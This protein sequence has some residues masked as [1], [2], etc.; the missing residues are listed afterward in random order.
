MKYYSW[1]FL[2]WKGVNCAQRPWALARVVHQITRNLEKKSLPK[3]CNLA[4]V[5]ESALRVII[6]WCGA[7][8]IW[9]QRLVTDLRK[10]LNIPHTNGM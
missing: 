10:F 1:S 4:G 7:F 9:R 8:S 2:E 3:R 5:V 6:G